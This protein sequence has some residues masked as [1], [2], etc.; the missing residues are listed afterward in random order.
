MKNARPLPHFEKKLQDLSNTGLLEDN[1]LLRLLGHSGQV[2]L[3]ES[4]M[5]RGYRILGKN[6]TFAA[7]CD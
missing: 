3:E 5:P 7:A 1:D 4:M 2:S 6:F